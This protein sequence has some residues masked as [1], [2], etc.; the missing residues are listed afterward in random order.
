M[1]KLGKIASKSKIKWELQYIKATK[2][3][4]IAT[5]SFRL[6]AIKNKKNLQEGYY[7]GK[8]GEFVAEMNY[9][10]INILKEQVKENDYKIKLDRKFLIECL[11]ALDKTDKLDHIEL[12]INT[13]KTHRPVY[14]TNDNGYIMI[15][16]II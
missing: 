11:N 7:H 16:P 5:D 1:K 2:E 3:E 9:P 15:M 8:T 4:L 13:K 14:I 6:V 10:E 12:S